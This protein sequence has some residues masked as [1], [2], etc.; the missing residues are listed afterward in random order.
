MDDG[1]GQLGMVAHPRK[2]WRQR[3]LLASCLGVLLGCTSPAPDTLGLGVNNE[4]QSCPAKHN[5]V[6]SL[7]DYRDKDRY[8]APLVA[9]PVTWSSLPLVLSAQPNLRVVEQDENYLRAEATSRFLRFVDDLEF[10]FRPD[11]GLIHVRS[12]SRIGYSDFGANRDR[13]EQIRRSLRLTI[14]SP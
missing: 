8:I 14:Q 5:C 6:S 10:Q 2:R 4:L 3:V 7:G 9:S 13:L 1:R 11:L 12:A